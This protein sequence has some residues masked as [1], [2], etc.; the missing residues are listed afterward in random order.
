[1]F[2]RL[3]VISAS[4]AVAAS[5]APSSP[6]AAREPA[7]ISVTTWGSGHGRGLSQYGARNRANAGQTYRQIVQ[8]Y[9]P[10]TRW[11]SA[12]GS[13]RILLSHDTSDDVVVDARSKLE[14]RSLGAHKT[15]NLP[16]KAAG[17]KITRWR[18][19]QAGSAS[20]ISYR[21]GSWHQWRRAAGD[22]QFAAGGRPITLH[23]P[24]GTTRYRGTL[25]SATVGSGRDTVNVVGLDAYLRG[26]VPQEVPALWPSAAVRAQAVAART[27]AAHERAHAPAGRAYDLCDT[28]QCQV[29]GGSDAEHPSSDAAVQATAGRIV[30]YDGAPAFAQFSAS[31]GGYSVDGGLPYLVARSDPFDHGIPGDP[32]RQ[33][34][35]GE[36]V[37]RHWTGLGDLVSVEVI[38]RDGH[39]TDDV[40]EG[41]ATM[42][43]VTG[44]E[45]SVDVTGSNFRSYLGLRSTLLEVTMM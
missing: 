40:P 9:Y 19:T 7:S 29:Y 36:E 32:H 45:G 20:V 23:T 42:L 14:A 38:E 15:W 26:V 31:N 24:D 16:A 43:R 10:S 12:A 27:Y 5:V 3:A 8:H 6:A 37:T 1:M 11:G 22:A 33:T 35:T 30:T 25:R 28:D 39:G 18:I 4:L 41:R 44:T 13:V 34:F 21:T 2:R 17:R